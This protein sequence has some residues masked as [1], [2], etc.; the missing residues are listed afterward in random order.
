MNEPTEIQALQG[1][2]KISRRLLVSSSVQPVQS[3]DTVDRRSVDYI[4]F[5]AHVDYTQNAKFIDEVMPAHLILVHGE[6][7]N[8]SRLRSAL[9]TK[10]AERKDDIQIYTPRNVEIVKLKFRGERMAKVRPIPI[11][12]WVS[13]T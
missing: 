2:A 8:M 6:A 10:F 3:P 4:S 9:K 5:S 12:R 13:L 1:G 7:N 11:V